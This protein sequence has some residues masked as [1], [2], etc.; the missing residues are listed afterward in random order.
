MVDLTDSVV[1]KY[2]GEGSA[3][4]SPNQ[5]DIELSISLFSR[6]QELNLFSPQQ[7]KA[8]L[9]VENESLYEQL[10]WQNNAYT[11]RSQPGTSKLY[12]LYAA[13]HSLKDH[14]KLTHFSAC[15]KQL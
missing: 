1:P 11:L 12:A 3:K 13:A 8:S 5:K 7:L 2:Y 10:I 6:G 15:F 4:F 14:N 9:P